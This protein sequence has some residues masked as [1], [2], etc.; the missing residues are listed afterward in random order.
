MTDEK[1]KQDLIKRHAEWLRWDQN[2]GNPQLAD[3]I[4]EQCDLAVDLGF[5]N[6]ALSE[7]LEQALSWLKW[8]RENPGKINHNAVLFECSARDLLKPEAR[9][10]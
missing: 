5:R 8:H 3:V 9:H 1:A 4:D 2:N 10:D 6:A 7:K